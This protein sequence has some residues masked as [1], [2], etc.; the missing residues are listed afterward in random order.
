MVVSLIR[1]CLHC[2]KEFE[3]NNPQKLYCNDQHYRPCP[4]C[5]KPVAMIDND[6]SRPAKCC[7]NECTK[8]LRQQKFAE[9]ICVECGQPFTP[10]SGIQQICD[11]HHTRIC[12]I[13]GNEF[14]A[15]RR[16][17]QDNVVVCCHECSLEFT[18]QQNILKCATHCTK[19]NNCIEVNEQINTKVEVI[20]KLDELKINHLSNKQI[21]DTMFDICL[22]DGKTLIEIDPS[23][24]H[25]IVGNQKSSGVLA[26]YHLIKTKLAERHG[27]CCVHIFDWDNVNKIVNLFLPRISIYA[28][29]CEIYRINLPAAADFVN[30]YHLQGSCK[31][32]LLCLGLVKDDVL[33]QIMAFGKARYDKEHDIELL[34]LCTRAGYSVVG[35]ASKLFSYATSEYALNNI[36]SYCDVSK[37]SGD[38]YENIGMQLVDTLPPQIVWSKQ[39]KCVEAKL[40]RKR[41]YNQ[42]FKA[43]YDREISDEELM[44]TNGW[45]PVPNCGQKVFEYRR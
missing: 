15:S 1:K 18:R 19:L 41:R 39:D 28:R 14:D 45:L 29:D 31:G 32:Q 20:K 23:Y 9:R 33:Y 11:R 37:F 44:L 17:I 26:N 4:V 21:E 27:Y 5:G 34:R 16:D 22:P 12:K 13:C 43:A 10:R 36:I 3:T 30:T 8:I 35:G 24:T 25:N 40:L 38:V 6:F 2:G 7:S 42:L